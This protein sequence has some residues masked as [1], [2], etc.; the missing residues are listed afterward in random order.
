MLALVLMTVVLIG[1][2]VFAAARIARDSAVNAARQQTAS[3]LMVTAMLDQ[4]TG[5]RGYFETHDEIFLQPYTLGTS[6]FAQA[7]SESRSYAAGDLVLQRA[8]RGEARLSAQWHAATQAQ[9]DRLQSAGRAPTLAQAL[10]GKATMDEF[11][12]ANTAYDA[13]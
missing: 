12:A 5:A 11:R 4:E 8:L 7:L 2:T 1:G 3:E 13:N 10:A 9:I 6:A